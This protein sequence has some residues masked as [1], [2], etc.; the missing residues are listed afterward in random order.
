MP[1]RGSDDAMRLMATAEGYYLDTVYTA[2]A[3]AGL[4][5]LVARGA[6]GPGSRVLFLHTGGLSMT[7]AREKR[8]PGSG[9][10]RRAAPSAVADVVGALLSATAPRQPASPTRS[11]ARQR[12]TSAES[13]AR[14]RLAAPPPWRHGRSS[15]WRLSNEL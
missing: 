15:S 8:Y 6:I 2:K 9:I 12:C 11:S 10:A 3:F 14:G 7:T 5:G 4:Q 13:R 1:N